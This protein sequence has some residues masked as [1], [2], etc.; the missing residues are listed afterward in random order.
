MDP[1]IWGPHAWFF[2]HSVAL[3]YPKQ[4]NETE[5]IQYYNFF[6]N[7]GNILPCLICREN[8]K[9]HL[10]KHSLK[11]SLNTRKDLHMW[12]INIHNEVNKIHKKKQY[13]YEEVSD[14]YNRIY[15]NGV[16]KDDTIFKINQD[17]LKLET[18]KNKNIND[19][20]ISKQYLKYIILLFFCL[21]ISNLINL[22]FLFKK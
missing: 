13:T 6:N 1:T 8:Y 2:L 22:F 18:K 19:K 20:S 14:L 5:K 17:K 9:N 10:I 3:M 7:L 12:L 4:P 16:S 11:N 15:N 21:I